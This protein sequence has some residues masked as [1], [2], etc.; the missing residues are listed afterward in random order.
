MKTTNKH[1]ELFKSECEYWQDI[2][3]LNGF[4]LRIYWNEADKNRAQLDIDQLEEGI[5][6]VNFGQEINPDEDCTTEEIKKSAKHEMIHALLAE[7]SYASYR[8][9]I[10]QKE[11]YLLEEKL[12]NKLEKLI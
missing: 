9:F 1:F 4:N 2:F 8:R 7:M 3:N 6:K 10:T 11:V 5:L 12:V